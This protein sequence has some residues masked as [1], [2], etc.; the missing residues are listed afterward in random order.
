MNGTNTTIGAPNGQNRSQLSKYTIPIFTILGIHVVVIGAL[1]L[2]G[3]KERPSGNVADNSIVTNLPSITFS[4]PPIVDTGLAPQPVVTNVPSTP[5]VVGVP[6]QPVQPVVAPVVPEITQA[7]PTIGEIEHV[8]AKGESFTT[9]AKQYGVSVDAIAKANP[10]VDSRRLKIG[11][12]IRIP[13]KS[14]GTTA[15][16]GKSGTTT[17]TS[18]AV[19][20]TTKTDNQSDVVVADSQVYVVKPGDNLTKIA[21]SYGVSIRD[22]KAANNLRTDR[23]NVGQKLKV[24][25][26]TAKAPAQPQPVQDQSAPVMQDQGAPLMKVPSNAGGAMIASGFSRIA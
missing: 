5:Q 14:G 19:R 22:L 17:T 3:C 25:M 23:I 15:V 20:S 7:A 21:K 4:N 18:G 6:T 10:G 16:A 2:Q 24:P 11:Q 13:E 9:I 1:L 26:K 8:V 12:K